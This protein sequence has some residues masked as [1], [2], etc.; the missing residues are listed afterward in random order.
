MQFRRVAVAVF[1]LAGIA[2]ITR[3][4]TVQELPR[5]RGIS[6]EGS[7]KAMLAESSAS[8]ASASNQADVKAFVCEETWGIFPCSSHAVAS[9]FL[10]FAYGAFLL[11]AA[12]FIS[13]GSELLL[14]ILDPGI[15]G[16]LVLPVLGALP[17]SMIIIVSG[18]GGT[19]AQAQEQVSVG[20][21][22]LAGSTIMLLTIAWGWCA[23]LARCDI[24]WSKPGGRAKDKKLSNK[25]DLFNTGFTVEP[26]TK[27]SAFIMCVTAL[28]YLIIQVPAFVNDQ[29]DR[30]FALVGLIACILSLI[31]YCVYQVVS[32]ELQQKQ[33]EAARERA[34]KAASIQALQSFAVKLPGQHFDIKD[35]KVD[36]KALKVYFKKF[37]IDSSGSINL[38]NEIKALIAA[39]QMPVNDKTIEFFK[40]LDS[41]QSGEISEEE[42]ILGVTKWVE[43]SHR[44]KAEHPD[45]ESE[46]Q[47]IFEA[48]EEAEEEEDD[49]DDDAELETL[50]EE[51]RR[52]RTIRMSA[53][54]L[55]AGI[56]MA[57]VF[58]DPMVDAISTFSKSTGLSA[59]L[60]SFVITP[61][62]SNASELVSSLIQ[63]AKKSKKNTTLTVAQIYGAVTMNNTM[64][65]GIFLAL[66]NIRGLLWIFSA[67]VFSILAVTWIVGSVAATR[68]TFPLWMAP[69]ALLLYPSSLVMY[70]YLDKFSDG[71]F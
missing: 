45:N 41:D 14:E 3:D 54:Y 44:E 40:Q 9:V 53:M 11:Q 58:S 10:M 37:D 55:V 36:Q 13:D 2:V 33:V 50:T 39:L 51:E 22:T 30:I 49:D 17:D 16:G 19:V 56:A 23:I 71:R 4:A 42:F 52:S 34:A 20:V 6:E 43:D 46:K 62:A 65:L 32:P 18:I 25:F 24:D 59:F 48:E 5:D 69:A 28:L 26:N 38:D 35:G 63:S 70:Y 66:V 57:A 8:S 29:L 47:H 31:A 64:C 68:I 67:E 7:L 60:V 27:G 61:F 12:K 1:V 21:G 15:I